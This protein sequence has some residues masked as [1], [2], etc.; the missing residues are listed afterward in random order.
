M[1]LRNS[2]LATIMISVLSIGCFE[3]EGGNNYNLRSAGNSYGGVDLE[4]GFIAIKPDGKAFLA[5]SS[6]RL[7]YGDIEQG[8]NQ[9]I[10]SIEKPLSIA[11]SHNRDRI[12][13]V[14]KTNTAK[15]N[16]CGQ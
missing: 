15:R 8:I 4:S 10:D 1:I 11:F 13:L 9:S 12:F 5:E 14:T 7:Y 6:G 2:F 16:S 3:F